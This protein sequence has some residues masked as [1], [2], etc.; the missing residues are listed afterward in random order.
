MVGV[1]VGWGGGSET[2]LTASVLK[3][4]R[5]T[6]KVK[7]NAASLDNAKQRALCFVLQCSIKKLSYS[8]FVCFDVLGRLVLFVSPPPS[9]FSYT[10][11]SSFVLPYFTLIF[12][13]PEVLV[14][15]RTGEFSRAKI[16][17]K[18]NSGGSGCV[19]FL[20]QTEIL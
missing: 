4:C 20:N 5:N 3:K 9:E 12:V 14:C 7:K 17:V 6:Q 1:G 15:Q 19:M 10:K 2:E 18:L 16:D 11:N 8:P 13:C